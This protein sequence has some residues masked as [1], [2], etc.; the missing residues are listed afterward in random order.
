LAGCF[1]LPSK[2]LANKEKK[3]EAAEAKLSANEVQQLEVG[4]DYLYSADYS[5]SLNPTP[6]RHDDVAKSLTERGLLATGL[7]PAEESFKLQKMVRGLVSTN[8]DAV[9]D[10]EKML[11]VKDKDIIKLQ[12]ENTDIKKELAKTKEEYKA[13]ATQ[14]ALDANFKVKIMRWVRFIFYGVIVALIIHVASLLVPPPYNAPLHIVSM[15]LGAIGR[16]IFKAAPQAAEF[17]GAVSKK[18]FQT[19]EETLFN[20][21]RSIQQIKEKKPEVFTDIEPILSAEMDMQ[22]KIKVQ[23][24]KRHIGKL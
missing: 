13:V 19:S 14:A 4:R 10:G 18:T 3:M 24:L 22:N 6:N 9:K 17:A 20:L 2:K 15:F 21:V 1:A 7:P 5:L 11:A 16:G 12:D 8:A 23:E